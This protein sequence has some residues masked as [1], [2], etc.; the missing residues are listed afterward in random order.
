MALNPTPKECAVWLSLHLMN[1]VLLTFGLS[2]L[3]IDWLNID[4]DIM[5]VCGVSMTVNGIRLILLEQRH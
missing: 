2:L 4:L 3:K 5:S 1:C